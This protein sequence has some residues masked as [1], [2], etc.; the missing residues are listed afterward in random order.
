MGII[1][2][3]KFTCVIVDIIFDIII[4]LLF[5]MPTSNEITEQDIKYY[6]IMIICL[7]VLV[8]L[9]NILF[10]YILNK[11]Y[12]PIIITDCNNSQFKNWIYP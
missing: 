9:I 12:P 3:I 6:T 1:K 2:Y 4:T 5:L 11:I 10:W 7:V 8:G